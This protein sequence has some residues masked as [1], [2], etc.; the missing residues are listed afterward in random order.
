MTQWTMRAPL[1]FWLR[2]VVYS[3]GWFQCAPFVWDVESA[4]LTRVLDRPGASPIVV[5]IAEPK[6]RSIRIEIRDFEASAD[7]RAAVEAA[8]ARI[9]DLE[10]DLEPFHQT[11]RGHQKL[12][13][14]VELGAG[15]IMRCPTLWEELVKSICGTNVAW[16]QAVRMIDRVCEL[17]EPVVG[18]DGLHAWPGPTVVLDAG[19]GVLRE[20]CRVGYRAGSILELA[21]RIEEGDLDLGPAERGELAENELR[22]LFLSVKGIGKATAAYLMLVSG[23]GRDISIDSSVYAYTAQAYFDGRK[24]S[25]DEIRALYEPFG[26]WAGRAQWFDGAVNAWWPALG[27]APE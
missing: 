27:I 17:G 4:T 26:E 2:P 12:N 1:G 24:P 7:E 25:D 9:L 8:V 15:R 21:C 11:C 23:H 18:T 16:K 14:V 5:H 3:H 10:R 20:H 13:G 22:A 6:A 19:E